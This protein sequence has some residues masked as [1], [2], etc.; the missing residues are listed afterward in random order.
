MYIPKEQGKVKTYFQISWALQTPVVLLQDQ[1]YYPCLFS[2]V[3]SW[4][5]DLSNAPYVIDVHDCD[6]FAFR[7]KGVADEFTNAV[8]IVL[9]K[10]LNTWHVWNM[11]ITNKGIRQVEPQQGLYFEHDN[12]Y[13]P[14]IVLI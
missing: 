5:A 11:A 12:R 8:G 3:L 7:Y 1:Q 13:R 14:M 10:Y 9:G 2:Q 6:N 4:Q